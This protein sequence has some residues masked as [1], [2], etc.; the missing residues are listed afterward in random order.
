MPSRRRAIA[1]QPLD[2]PRRPRGR[3]AR[4]Q[5][6]R[7]LEALEHDLTTS[8]AAVHQHGHHHHGHHHEPEEIQHD[9]EE[10]LVPEADDYPGPAPDPESD[11]ASSASS[12]TDDDSKSLVIS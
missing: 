9:I 8:Q 11:T 1:G 12:D 10:P 4:A 5:A 2:I 7:D 6:I 3:Q